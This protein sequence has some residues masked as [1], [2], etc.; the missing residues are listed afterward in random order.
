M[1]KL[2]LSIETWKTKTPFH[3]TGRVFDDV[4]FLYVEIE[5]DGCIGRGEAAGIYYFGETSESLI[6][7][8]EQLRQNIQMGLSRQELQHKLGVGGARNALDCAAWDLEAKLSGK[9]IWQLTDLAM[10][11]VYT[12]NTVGIDSPENMAT[13]AKVLDTPLIKVKLDADQPLQRMRA[14]CQARPDAKFVVDI[15]QGWN[16]Q[17]LLTYAPELKALGVMMIE[18]PLPRGEDS[19]LAGYDSPVDLCA[20]ESCIASYEVADMRNRYQMIN[21]KLDKT[22]G[23]TEALKTAKVARQN[24]MKLM[25]G[26]MLGTSLSMAPSFVIAQLCD[27]VDI[28]GP[29]LLADDRDHKMNFTGG[30]VHG[31]SRNLWG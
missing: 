8:A 19:E 17:E 15:N 20:D 10:K 23:L 21:I 28:D 16:F 13:A 30:K 18:Q 7:D 27:F 24:G 31:F 25:V 11:P 14:I 29:V 1:R 3:I 12:V 22:G 2:R 5:Q 26:N 9:T 6:S 4:D